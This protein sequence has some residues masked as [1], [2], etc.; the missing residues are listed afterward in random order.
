VRETHP[1]AA[2][3]RQNSGVENKQAPWAALRALEESSALAR[4][5]AERVSKRK[6]NAVATRFAERAETTE[7]HARLIRQILLTDPALRKHEELTGTG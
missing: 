5:S 3:R 7:E 2:R 6:L 4:R 1:V